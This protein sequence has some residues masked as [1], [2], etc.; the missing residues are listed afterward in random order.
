MVKEMIVCQ[1]LSDWQAEAS[2]PALYV[3]SE[4]RF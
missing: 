4:M 1:S 3:L 2:H